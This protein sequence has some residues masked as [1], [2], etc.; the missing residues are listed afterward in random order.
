MA[1]TLGNAPRLTTLPTAELYESPLNPRQHVN[2]DRL[3]ELVASIRQ[4]GILV[5][6]VVRERR[7]SAGTYEIAAGTRRWKAA[8]AIGMA[9]VPA[10]VRDLDDVAFLEL[11][12]VENPQHDQLHPMDEAEGYRTLMER[13]GYDVAKIAE[14]CGWSH[15]YV[16]DRLQLLRLV[17]PARQLFRAGRFTIRHAILISG[18]SA[19]RQREVLDPKQVDGWRADGPLWRHDAP[20]LKDGDGTPKG[21]RD[22]YAGLVAR[23]PRELKAWIDH[24]VRFDPD[25]EDLAEL[26]PET[27][28][29]LI[30]AEEAE[31]KVVHI[32]REWT[33]QR[34]ARD[35]DAPRVYGPRSWKR[36]DT[37]C[38]HQAL[39]VVLVGDGRGESFPVCVEKKK[40]AVH[41]KAEQQEA[42]KRR[43]ARLAEGT[44]PAADAAAAHDREL[45][46][47]RAREEKEEQ[48]RR[49]WEKAKPALL[50]AI[51]EALA[52]PVTVDGPAFR[53]LMH[54]GRWKLKATT[55]E[56]AVRELVRAELERE[57]GHWMMFRDAPGVLKPFGIDARAVV[58]DAVPPEPKP[59]A[60][61]KRTPRRKRA[62]TRSA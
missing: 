50:A 4:S 12:I 29:Q 32:T 49:R 18:L 52:A 10:I 1:D 11:L 28:E 27:A 37:P 33:V 14:R 47:W 8:T 56:D 53:F 30:A 58:D 34:S 6:I 19:D 35:P 3:A 62:V 23:S 54:L 46:R 21:K 5:P 26:F 16:Y 20:L 40:C 13:A 31:L 15:R 36:A 22:P 51:D 57:L 61:G 9:D 43:K 7:G 39:G 60:K 48:L 25:A 42:A 41:W 44:P 17:A 55:L 45:A 59:T 38:D 2:P 24:H